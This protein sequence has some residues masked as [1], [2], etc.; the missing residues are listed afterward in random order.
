MFSF[1]VVFHHVIQQNSKWWKEMRTLR[2]CSSWSDNSV[3]NECMKTKSTQTVSPQS[4]SL[5]R[6]EANRQTRATQI[7]PKPLFKNHTERYICCLN[8]CSCWSL[9]QTLTKDKESWRRFSWLFKTEAERRRVI[10]FLLV[11]L[12]WKK[13]AGC[14]L[15]VLRSVL[16]F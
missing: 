7:I 14:C 1:H 10:L 9:L 16:L 2:M 11:L 15:Q 8:N 13:C 3:F 12:F 6:K 5:C 4:D